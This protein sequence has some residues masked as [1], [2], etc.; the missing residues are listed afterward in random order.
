MT[1]MT[2]TNIIMSLMVPKFRPLITSL[3]LLIM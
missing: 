1:K 3:I 2:Y